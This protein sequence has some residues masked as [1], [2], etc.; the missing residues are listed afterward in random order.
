MKWVDL[1]H[2]FM[3]SNASALGFLA[4]NGLFSAP[5]CC[6]KGHEWV[7]Y[8]PEE[9]ARDKQ[10][11]FRCNKKVA[12]HGFG[13]KTRCGCSASW[14]SFSPFGAEELPK[15]LPWQILGLLYCFGQMRPVGVAA[16]E[17]SLSPPTCRAFYRFIRETLVTFMS[18]QQSALIGSVDQP[19]CIDE[20]HI[21]VKK[22]TRSGFQGKT[23]RGHE[24]VFMGSIE[25]DSLGKDRK[26]TGRAFLMIIRTWGI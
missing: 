8:D 17:L 23:T 13:P 22:Q 20:T 16:F 10:P 14:L 6:P 1:A 2:H 25:L 26:T 15:V 9:G 18:E 12:K 5:K 19:V 21:T 3:G 24:Q 11:H 4:L 7:L